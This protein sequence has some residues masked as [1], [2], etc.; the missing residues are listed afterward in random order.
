MESR[1]CDGCGLSLSFDEASE[2]ASDEE[3]EALNRYEILEYDPL[4][5]SDNR[6]KEFFGTE[7]SE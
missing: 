4:F 6:S 1:V 7:E 5:D 2:K 3:K